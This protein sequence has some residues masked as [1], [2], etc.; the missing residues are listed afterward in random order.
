LPLRLS[1][2]SS[3]EVATTSS[4][5]KYQNANHLLRFTLP[6]RSGPPPPSRRRKRLEP[7]NKERFLQ[8]NFRFSVTSEGDYQ[9]E[10]AEPDRLVDWKSIEQV[11]LSS[12]VLVSCPICLETPLA[13]K[14]TKCGHIFCWPCILRY[15]SYSA[16]YW[17]RCP[18]CLDAVGADDLKSVAVELAHVY[19]VGQPISFVLL[20]RAK[21]SSV[22][23]RP[24]NGA[25]ILQGECPLSSDV[26]SKFARLTCAEDLATLFALEA[27][28]LQE[29]KNVSEGFDDGNL[30]F[31]AMAEGRLSKR[32]SDYELHK[33]KAKEM[34]VLESTAG[35][36]GG[37]GESRSMPTKA[38]GLPNVL[39]PQ[40]ASPRASDHLHFRSAFYDDGEGEYD[41]EEEEEEEEEELR[42]HTVDT[43]ENEG[44]EGH[45]GHEALEEEEEE[46]EEEGGGV[47]D[48]MVDPAE[49][50]QQHTAA[51]NSSTADSPLLQGGTH[52]HAEPM[53]GMYFF[54]QAMDGQ[55]MYLHPLNV[56][57]L[58]HE[59]GAH[60]KFPHDLQGVIL[61]MERVTMT[62]EFR[63][64][65]RWLSL[66]L[67]ADFTLCEIDVS[68]VCSK[69][70][71]RHFAKELKARWTSRMA[72]L[73]T[74]EMVQKR[75]NESHAEFG[76][77]SSAFPS[78]GLVMP[79]QSPSSSSSSLTRERSASVG[80]EEIFST[81]SHPGP[82]SVSSSSTSAWSLS[83][84]VQDLNLVEAENP[85][86]QTERSSTSAWPSFADVLT[87]AAQPK[88]VAAKA[89]PSAVDKKGKG[90]KTFLMTTSLRGSS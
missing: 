27:S 51:S 33:Q 83:V 74:T 58:L 89:G 34:S 3:I 19:R 6:Q 32:R 48:K 8:A 59:F 47:L 90:K 37:D 73:R 16:H 38:T 86:H 56:K 5:G 77:G 53:D 79:L 75:N 28:Q 57:C 63:K 15:L 70:T 20:Q 35:G 60:A 29:L 39:K 62:E 36:A 45:E 10:M 87:K 1:P 76:D 78:P 26:D 64:R 46:E 43:E 14:I 31:I 40:R 52:G 17:R 9:I 23:F 50:S 72:K 69:A 67:G 24:A 30:P 13:A 4:R 25:R 84:P 85:A 88:V 2:S 7:Y 82:D 18:I 80:S 41:D 42:Q 22:P 55:H 66:P 12:P 11:T 61:E 81:M 71:L 65:H 21:G 44:L 54:Y 49:G 68:H